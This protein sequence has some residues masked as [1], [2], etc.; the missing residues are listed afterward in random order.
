MSDQAPSPYDQISDFYLNFVQNG[1]ADPNSL[2]SQTTDYL[3]NMLNLQPGVSVLDLCCGEGNLSRRIAEFPV[4]VTGTDI[5]RV[6][7]TRAQSYTPRPGNLSYVLDD[8]QSLS[9]FA[10]NEFDLVVCK[11]ALMDIPDIEAAFGAVA[12]VIKPQGRFV[13]ALLH[14]CFETP[15][16][17]PFQPLET[18]EEGNFAHLRVQRYFDEGHWESGGLGVR[19]RVGAY[20]RTLSTIVNGLTPAG[21]QITRLEEPQFKVGTANSLEAQWHNNIARILFLETRWYF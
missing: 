9:K 5:S 4:I 14:P 3:L 7:L 19:G 12:R 17:V 18:D 11:M 2:Y 10:S 13:M 6:N 20:H 21:F 1:L 15:F 16:K 8:A